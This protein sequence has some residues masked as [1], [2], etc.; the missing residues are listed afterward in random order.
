[1]WGHEDIADAH[2]SPVLYVMDEDNLA[3][4]FEATLIRRGACAAS[5]PLV[6]GAR[7]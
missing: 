7:P 1:M 2:L 6:L 3:R 5:G 4:V